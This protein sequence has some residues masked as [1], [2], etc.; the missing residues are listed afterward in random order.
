MLGPVNEL[1][2]CEDS[3]AKLERDLIRQRELR[4]DPNLQVYW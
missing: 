3:T 2:L 4:A 1:M